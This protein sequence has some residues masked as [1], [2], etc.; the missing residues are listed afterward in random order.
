MIVSLSLHTYLTK[1]LLHLSEKAD[2]ALVLSNLAGLEESLGAAAET[3]SSK[4]RV[5]HSDCCSKNETAQDKAVRS[6]EM[7]SN[8]PTCETRKSRPR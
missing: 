5:Q 2:E 7:I 1:M 6:R 3:F 8:A 4:Y